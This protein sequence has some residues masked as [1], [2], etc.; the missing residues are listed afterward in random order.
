MSL[1]PAYCVSFPRIGDSVTF[2]DM[3]G[4]VV[5][6]VIVESSAKEVLVWMHGQKDGRVCPFVLR[7]DGRYQ[8]DAIADTATRGILCGNEDPAFNVVEDGPDA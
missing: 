8:W 7:P 2:K 4:S 5:S 3:G 6:G 1:G